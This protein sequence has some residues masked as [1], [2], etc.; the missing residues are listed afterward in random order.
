MYTAKALSFFFLSALTHTKLSHAILPYLFPSF[1]ASIFGPRLDRPR[2]SK[3]P[4]LTAKPNT[5]VAQAST[6]AE[7]DERTHK[8]QQ[9][10]SNT[11]MPHSVVHVPLSQKETA[12][13]AQEISAIDL[14]RTIEEAL[15]KKKDTD[16]PIFIN[17]NLNGQTV[18]KSSAV[19]HA[20]QST[21]LVEWLYKRTHQSY[22]SLLEWIKDNKKKSVFY[23]LVGGYCSTQ[24]YLWY[25]GYALSKSTCWSRWKNHCSL[26][27]LYRRKQSELKQEILTEARNRSASAK[28]VD[29]GALLVSFLTEMDHELSL[30]ESYRTLITTLTTIFIGKIFFYNTRLYHEISERIN[31]LLFIKNT[32]LSSICTSKTEP[33]CASLQNAI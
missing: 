28:N 17:V 23:C 20:T 27:D 6:V 3:I 26:E 12:D 32:M 15:R 11:M 2:T 8:G 16:G 10:C 7:N 21:D 33:F 4:A 22:Q 29:D 25:L 30:L 1:F 9:I 14:P 31:R 13:L 18:T 5:L 19:A 24:A